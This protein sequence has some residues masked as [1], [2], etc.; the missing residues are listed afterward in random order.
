[1]IGA[2]VTSLTKYHKAL[3]QKRSAEEI[4]E[5]IYGLSFAGKDV[6]GCG[7]QKEK[8]KPVLEN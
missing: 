1:M 4:Q 7:K 5:V 6:E 3:R 2:Q 8:R